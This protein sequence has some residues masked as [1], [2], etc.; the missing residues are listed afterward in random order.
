MGQQNTSEQPAS[1][2]GPESIR[3]LLPTETLTILNPAWIDSDSVQCSVTRTF[4][5]TG[6][7]YFSAALIAETFDL[8]YHA[9]RKR[10]E[11]FRNS[12]GKGEVTVDSENSNHP[13]YLYRL[14]DVLPEIEALQCGKNVHRNI[15]RKQ[16]H[17]EKVKKDSRIVE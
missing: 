12:P 17:Q 1:E 14:L 3:K 16:L 10:L 4:H 15:I 6:T 8:P 9:L 13:K 2:A 7:E 11:R 5:L